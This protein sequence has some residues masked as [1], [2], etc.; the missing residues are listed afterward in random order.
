MTS[1]ICPVT[2][3]VMSAENWRLPHSRLVQEIEN[4]AIK[5]DVP[6]LLGKMVSYKYDLDDIKE[7]N[8]HLVR[9]YDL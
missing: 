7:S 1:K 5:W 2:V 3:T 4:L 6:K 9:K 8:S